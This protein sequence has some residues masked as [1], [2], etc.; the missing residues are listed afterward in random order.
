MAKDGKLEFAE[1]KYDAVR[2]GHRRIILRE[3]ESSE[4]NLVARTLKARHDNILSRLHLQRAKMRTEDRQRYV[5]KLGKVANPPPIALKG[6][7]MLHGCS[8]T[9]KVLFSVGI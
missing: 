5:K 1:S 8:K 6:N 3:G 2:V 4:E 7:V 9:Q